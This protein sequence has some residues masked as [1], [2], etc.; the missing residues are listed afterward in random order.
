MNNLLQTYNNIKYIIIILK[1]DMLIFALKYKTFD[2]K[3]A[4]NWINQT[5]IYS[6]Y[7]SN[8]IF[9]RNDALKEVKYMKYNIIRHKK[10]TE[11]YWIGLFIDSDLC[12]INVVGIFENYLR[13]SDTIE[14][15]SKTLYNKLLSKCFNCFLA[16]LQHI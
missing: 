6:F 14:K 15:Q 5:K 3:K 11:F 4:I 10:V 8:D 9:Y 16:S 13:I 12:Y 7:I 1:I 2:S